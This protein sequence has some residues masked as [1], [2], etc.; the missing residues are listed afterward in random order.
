MQAL[1]NLAISMFYAKFLHLFILCL[2][3]ACAVENLNSNLTHA[4]QVTQ[5]F[6]QENKHKITA[7]Y[8]T[9]IFVDC[10]VEGCDSSYCKVYFYLMDNN[11]VKTFDVYGNHKGCTDDI[12]KRETVDSIDNYWKSYEYPTISINT[13]RCRT[14]KIQTSNRITI[15]HNPPVSK[16]YEFFKKTEDNMQTNVWS[17]EICLSAD[18]LLI[19]YDYA[20]QPV[21]L[22]KY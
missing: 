19:G 2:F 10:R 7:K 4:D 14:I 5:Q 8:K 9:N 11:T 20:N 16:Q 1:K 13:L 6:E 22:Y 12:Y 18:T 21:Y 3:C 15:S 17:Q